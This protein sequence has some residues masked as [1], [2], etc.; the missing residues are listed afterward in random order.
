MMMAAA[1]G[2]IAR[3]GNKD[4]EADLPSDS[5]AGSAAV[6]TPRVRKFF[7]E[8]WI[9]TDATCSTSSDGCTIETV[10]PDT[11]TSWE[12][13]AFSM[14][15]E[16]GLQVSPPAEPLTVFKPFFSLLSLPRVAKRQEW[17]EV[18]AAVFN[19]GPD[20]VVAETTL[21]LP[22]T[23]ILEGDATRSLFIESGSSVT[24]YFNISATSVGIDDI[25][26]TARVVEGTGTGSDA[27]QRPLEVEAEGLVQERT[28]NAVLDPSEPAGEAVQ[29]ETSFPQEAVERSARA[30][31][32]IVGD[33]LG[34]TLD[35]LERLVRLP[36]GCG[37]QTMITFAP[38]V[39]VTG[40]LDAV[41]SLPAELQKSLESN[42][43]VGL[44]RELTY[45]H[46]D[47]SFSA[48]GESDDSGST[49]LTA[50]VLKSFAQA[51]AFS[52]V[53]SQVLVGATEFL[54]KSQ[55]PDGSFQSIGKVIHEDMMGGVSGADGKVSLTSFCLVALLEA[56]KASSQVEAKMASFD[57]P[58]ERAVSFLLESSPSTRSAQRRNGGKQAYAAAISAY[59]LAL[60]RAY[61][62]SLLTEEILSAVI[63]DLKSLGTTEDGLAQLGW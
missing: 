3:R 10:A 53:D 50:F 6:A 57:K 45:R 40:Y 24:A 30:S 8:T 44:Q 46:P 4:S 18:S 7:P 2:R 19:Y 25:L 21:S 47:G 51:S 39:Y 12:L 52:F 16:Q 29:F 43:A 28:T 5:S 14:G 36:T 35:G 34:P 27:V 59:A 63:S 58:L 61:R 41:N 42:I 26:F 13:D 22:A 56:A 38:Q 37:E 23:I 17:I 32:S 49:W 1:P 9:W 31:V 60:A 33:L 11:I 48:F 54:L 15:S 62:P 20:A 55:R